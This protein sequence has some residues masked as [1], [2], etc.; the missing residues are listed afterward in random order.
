LGFIKGI[1]KNQVGRAREE[2]EKKLSELE[3]AQVKSLP[4]WQ[5]ERPHP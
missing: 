5:R 3:T 2:I 1:N 4:G